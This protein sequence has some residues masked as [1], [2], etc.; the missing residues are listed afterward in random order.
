M[1][2]Q[3]NIMNIKEVLYTYCKGKQSL[4]IGSL[5]K[6]RNLIDTVLL[7]SSKQKFR[8]VEACHYLVNKDYICFVFHDKKNIYSGGIHFITPK[9]WKEM[10]F[11][12]QE[13]EL[14]I[15][16]EENQEKLWR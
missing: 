9:L 1:I 11:T 14:D 15:P 13:D 6:L 8:I 4:K 12:E 7:D 10:Q 2:S 16:K 3:E 5:W